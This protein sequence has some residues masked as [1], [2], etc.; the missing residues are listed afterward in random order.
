MPYKRNDSPIYWASYTDASGR[1]VRR[2]TGTANAREAA[3]IEAKWKLEAHEE[4]RWGIE[5]DRSIEEVLLAWLAEQYE[6]RSYGSNLISARHWRRLLPGQTIRDMTPRTLQGFIAARR[7]EGAGPATINRNLSCLQAAINWCNKSL[8]WGLPVPTRG[9]FL[10]EPEGR[11]RWLSFAEADR[12]MA[13]ARAL[14]RAIH[15]AEFIELALNTGM[16]RGELLFL[17]WSRVDMKNRLIHLEAEHTKTKR[18]RCVPINVTARAVLLRLFSFRASHCPA[19]PWVF[20]R[21]DGKRLVS[22]KGGFVKACDAAGIVNFHIHDLRHTCAA[23]LTTAGVPLAEVR[24][25][26]GHASVTMTERYAHLAPENVRA[27][28]ARLDNRSRFGHADHV[29]DVQQ[30]ARKA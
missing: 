26:L 3:A 8:G 10:Q 12:L 30:T 23:W 18:R 15:S 7:A 21:T 14:P 24:D 13:A 22:V 11:L 19:S 9:R 6:Q 17:E 5:P 27:A 4:K 29:E 16:R 20:C 2:S 28:V 25:L 1:R